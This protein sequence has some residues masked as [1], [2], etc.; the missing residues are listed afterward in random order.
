MPKNK[1]YLATALRNVTKR[2]QAMVKPYQSY[3]R[4][5]PRGMSGKTIWPGNKRSSGRGSS[6]LRNRSVKRGGSRSRSPKRSTLRASAPSWE[7][8][9]PKLKAPAGSKTIWAASRNYDPKSVHGSAALRNPHI[10]KG[11]ATRRRHH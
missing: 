5:K 1:S 8:P 10:K 2:L 3:T 11:G 4:S 6:K 9:F 7:P